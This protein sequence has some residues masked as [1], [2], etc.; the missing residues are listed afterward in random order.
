MIKVASKYGFLLGTEI[1]HEVTFWYLKI[2]LR[3]VSFFD[4]IFNPDAII[5]YILAPH[6]ILEINLH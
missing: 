4:N 2:I 1:L 5:E 3:D 6:Q